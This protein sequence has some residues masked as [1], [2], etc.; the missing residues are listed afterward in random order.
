[1]NKIQTLAEYQQLASR[2]CPDLG[3][4][5]KNLLHMNLGIT[6]EV[7]EFL[8]VIKKNLAY[9][10]P[11]DV[12]NLG[13]ELADMAWYIAN[14]ARL[15]FPVSWE[16]QEKKHSYESIRKEFSEIFIPIYSE[17]NL[18]TRLTILLNCGINPGTEDYIVSEVQEDFN[19]MRDM[20]ILNYVADLHNLDFF[21]L[22][23][24][25]ITKLQ[26]RYPEKFTNE[27]ALNRDL[28]AERQ[29]LEITEG[30]AQVSL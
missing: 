15:F 8:D 12:V 13:E 23:T 19:G 21:Q 17:Y 7:G 9:G 10:K 18:E 20:V 14:K 30:D 16:E 26:V 6:T 25:N 5:E 29:Q 1:M 4:P 2:T 11:L 3:T 28:D 24:N 27:A 22:L